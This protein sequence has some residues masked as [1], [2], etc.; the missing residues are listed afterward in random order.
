MI[1]LTGEVFHRR[2]IVTY[3]APW[4]HLPGGVKYTRLMEQRFGFGCPIDWLEYLPGDVWYARL[5]EQRLGIGCPIDW[6]EYLPGDVLYARLMEQRRFT[7]WPW[8]SSRLA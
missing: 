1:Y 7:Q 8:S 4:K 2:Y 3:V 6:F 5:M